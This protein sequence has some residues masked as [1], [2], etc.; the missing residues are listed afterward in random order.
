MTENWGLLGE[1][2]W[3][4]WS[5]FKELRVVFDNPRQPD[6]VVEENWDDTFRLSLGTDYNLNDEWTLRG[7]LTYDES[8]VPGP[9]H[10]TPRIPDMDRYWL[11]LGLG[12]DATE[13]LV[14]DLGYVHIFVEDGESSAPASNGAMLIGDWSSHVDLVSASITWKM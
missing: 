13:N 2:A 1:V 12:F 7:G 3:T 9:E 11:A 8:P 5:Q 10:R 6:S 4:R 14:I